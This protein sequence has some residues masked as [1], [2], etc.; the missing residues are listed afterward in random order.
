MVGNELLP[1]FHLPVYGAGAQQASTL[2]LGPAR[3]DFTI[4]LTSVR[5]GPDWPCG[6]AARPVRAAAPALS[7][8]RQCSGRYAGRQRGAWGIAAMSRRRSG[9]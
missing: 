5:V 6:S 3:D 7:M 2:V 8:S 4:V 1:Q 9:G